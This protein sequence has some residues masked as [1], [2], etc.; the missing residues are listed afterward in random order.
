MS[1]PDSIETSESTLD[2][3]S[4]ER[5]VGQGA[6]LHPFRLEE[7]DGPGAEAQGGKEGK[8]LAS[9]YRH[10]IISLS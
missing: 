8:L 6:P 7:E 9:L 1:A 2:V 5:A 4:P 3:P 10:Y